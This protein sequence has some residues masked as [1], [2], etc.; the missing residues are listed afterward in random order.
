MGLERLLINTFRFSD[1]STEIRRV[2]RVQG[3]GIRHLSPF[4]REERGVVLVAL[5]L[6][7][8]DDAIQ[9]GVHLVRRRGHV[10]SQRPFGVAREAQESGD[11]GAQRY[12]PIQAP[13][14]LRAARGSCNISLAPRR[15]V[16]R[17]LQ[18]GREGGGFE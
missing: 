13:R 16:P 9:E 12:D 6:Q 11:L 10:A 8:R 4:Q 17:V 18:Y 3:V 2:P 7:A 14:V 15:G 1:L 5:R